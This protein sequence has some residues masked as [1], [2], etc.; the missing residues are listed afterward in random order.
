MSISVLSSSA[1]SDHR[2]SHI[3]PESGGSWNR[4]IWSVA[5]GI[6]SKRRE[7]AYHVQVVDCIHVGTDATV[8]TK[9]LIVYYGRQR[10]SIENLHKRVV[11]RL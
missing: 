5:L 6:S 9:E 4:L 1:G 3:I 10:Q 7:S 8:C 11:H 2:T